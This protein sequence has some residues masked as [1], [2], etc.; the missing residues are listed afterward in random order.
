[1]KGLGCESV[2][3]IWPLLIPV[4]EGAYILHPGDVGYAERDIERPGPQNRSLFYC[5]PVHLVLGAVF[6]NPQFEA[7]FD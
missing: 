1:M 4:E 2:T 3:T 7:D 6:L 5:P